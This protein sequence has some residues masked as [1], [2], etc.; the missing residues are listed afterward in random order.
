MKGKM[1]K[2]SAIVILATFILGSLSFYSAVAATARIY[3]TPQNNIYTVDTAGVGTKFNVTIWVEN[4]VNIGGAQVYLEFN[5]TILRVTRW[6]EPRTDPQYVFNGKTTSAL[7]TPPDPGYTHLGTNRGRALISVSMF[8]PNPPFFNGNGKICIFEFNIT[9][10]PTDPGKFTSALII[11]TGDTYLLDGD[12]GDEVPGVLKT[13]GYYEISKAGPKYTLTISATSG[14]TTNPIPGNYLYELGTLVSVTALPAVNYVLDHWELDTVNVGS[15]NPIQVVMSKNYDLRAVFVFRPP[16][17]SRIFVDPP[18]IIDPHA[19]PC[20]TNFQINVSIDDIADMK[21][22]EFNLTYDTNVIS[23]IGLN[24]L[25]VNGQYPSLTLYVDDPAGFIWVKL[26]Y[27]TGKTVSNPTPLVTLMFHLDNLGATPLDLTNTKLNDSSGNPIPHDTYDGFYMAQIRDVAVLNVV[28][29]RAWAYPGWPINVTVT[30]KNK[31]N[32]SETFNVYAYYDTTVIGF[33]TVTVLA[34]NEVRDVIIEWDTTGVPEGNYTLKA[35][36]DTVPY[37]YNTADN[38]FIDGVVWIM[39]HIHDVAV[40]QVSLSDSWAFPGWLV[41]INVTALNMGDFTESFDVKAY[42][43]T[44]LIGTVH[45]FTLAPGSSYVAQFILDTT[46]LLPCHTQ[47]ISGEA[48]IVPYEFNATNNFLVDGGLTIRWLGDFNGD[49]KV[50]LRDVYRVQQAFG[51]YPGHPR[52]DP[53]CD[54]NRDGKID[55]RDV[56]AVYRNYGKSC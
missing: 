6:F 14:G 41:N 8:P 21:T 3:M 12:T 47:T 39:T 52:W 28:P 49:G 37:E 27:S 13:N 31:G 22:C 43:N 45:V 1:A 42:Y 16:E 29:S 46:S 5:D 25:K 35:V 55:L 56:F 53:V 48:T 34:P 26:A 40:V 19:I 11:N 4:A 17:G 30:V 9:K 50:D 32:I 24:F 38:T 15:A 36:A 10:V 33:K 23:I 54:I 7:P 18:E 51:S 44:T 2:F 20:T